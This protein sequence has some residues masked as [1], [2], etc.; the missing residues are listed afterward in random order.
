MNRRHFLRTLATVAAGVVLDPEML[1]W[2][3]G[4]KT[5]FLPPPQSLLAPCNLTRGDIFTVEGVYAINPMT[6]DVLLYEKQCVITANV[7]QG[8][9]VRGRFWPSFQSEGFYQNVS[10][11]PMQNAKIQACLIGTTIPTN[12]GWHGAPTPPF[13][14]KL[15]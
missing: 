5:I 4:V 11:E 9:S 7:R 3:P 2:R 1:L 6:L 15:R 14:S 12:A 10:N 8:E 13:T